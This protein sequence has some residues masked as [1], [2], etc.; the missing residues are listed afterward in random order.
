MAGPEQQ[1]SS[2]EN[3]ISPERKPGQRL[4][5]F[6]LENMPTE[7]VLVLDEAIQI[8]AKTEG[9]ARVLQFEDVSNALVDDLTSLPSRNFGRARELAYAMLHSESNDN[10]MA[11]TLMLKSLLKHEHEVG[12]THVDDDADSLMF[13]HRESGSEGSS[14]VSDCARMQIFDALAEGWLRPDI[15]DRFQRELMAD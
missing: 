7:V 12:D 5:Y 6:D 10:R 9:A 8:A 15:A 2:P 14:A 13:L 1:S 4:P 11:A 3:Q